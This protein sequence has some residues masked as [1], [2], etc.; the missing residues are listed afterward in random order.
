[1]VARD[2]VWHCLASMIL[3]WFFFGLIHLYC[4]LFCRRKKNE[5]HPTTI[6]DGNTNNRGG[7]ENTMREGQNDDKENRSRSTGDTPRLQNNQSTERH[8]SCYMFHLLKRTGFQILIASTLSF[9]V[10]G[11]KEFLDLVW[12]GWPWC[13]GVCNADGWDVLA[14]LVGIT[15]GAILLVLLIMLVNNR[16]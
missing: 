3:V 7:D 6:N 2:K 15:T 5:K 8:S 14:N 13:N 4:R 1:M 12:N 16:K 9:L 11:T 10:G